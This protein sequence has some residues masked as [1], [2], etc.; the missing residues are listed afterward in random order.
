[1]KYFPLLVELTKN[2]FEEYTE[3]SK[4]LLKFFDF[5]KGRFKDDPIVEILLLKRKS[6][7][8]KAHNK[9]DLFSTIINDLVK[10]KKDKYIF[11]YIPEGYTSNSEGET[12]KM[13]N[14]FLTR[15]HL[16][17]P[18]IK[19]NSYTSEDQNLSEVIRGFEEGKIDILFAM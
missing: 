5:E 11:A 6:I 14:E 13:L 4:K 12:V 9:I 10:S 8:H 1:Y 17:H 2:E 15:T 16:D 3:I 7:I 18:Q 19:M